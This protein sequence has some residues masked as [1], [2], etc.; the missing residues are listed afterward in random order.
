MLFRSSSLVPERS[1]DYDNLLYVCRTC[2]ALKATL[3]IPDPCR[4]FLCGTVMIQTNGTLTATTPEAER[5]I[6][7][8]A[9]NA[10]RRR[11]YRRMW[12]R[13]IEVVQVNDPN[14]YQVLMGYP[15][16]LPDIDRLRPPGGNAKP[17]GLESSYRTRRLRGELPDT[18]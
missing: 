3:P 5:I 8:L 9:L 10:E 1:L 7:L 15:M 6:E 17:E 11:E 2:N 13:I 14:L 18:Y 16:R 12:V 4:H